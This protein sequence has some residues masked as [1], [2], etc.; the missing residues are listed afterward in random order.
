[1]EQESDS[2]TSWCTWNGPQ[3]IRKGIRRVGN[4]RRNG[5]HSAYRIVEIGQIT[6]GS[7]EDLRGLAVT[8]TPMKS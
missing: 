6:E 2:D 5:D 7:P 3:R 4:R 8:Q 1:M